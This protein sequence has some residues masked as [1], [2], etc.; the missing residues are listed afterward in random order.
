MDIKRE[1]CAYIK[2]KATRYMTKNPLAA[3]YVLC[4]KPSFEN[5]FFEEE[6]ALRK[7]L[8]LSREDPILYPDLHPKKRLEKLIY[9]HN[10]NFTKSKMDIYREI[11]ENINID[12]LTTRDEELK[13]F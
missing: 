12:A 8:N 7:V 11:A 1:R 3:I 4:P 2:R 10:D 5:W 9:K 13:K 6:N